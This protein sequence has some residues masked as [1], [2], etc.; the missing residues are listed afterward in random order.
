MS[1]PFIQFM[2]GP[3]VPEGYDRPGKW[4]NI[5]AWA[6]P[7][8]QEMFDR[9]TCVTYKKC[10]GKKYFIEVRNVSPARLACKCKK[11]QKAN[12]L[13][14][15]YLRK[16]LRKTFET[17]QR[18]EKFE[19]TELQ[20]NDAYKIFKRIQG[21]LFACADAGVLNEKEDA[22]VYIACNKP[23]GAGD[24]AF[25]MRAITGDPNLLIHAIV[26][27]GVETPQ[28]GNI[29]MAAAEHLHHQRYVEAQRKARK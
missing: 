13:A 26:T 8:R 16:E 12:E 19:D 2:F 17:N 1:Q 3:Q 11:C 23:Q 27:S 14:K 15:E 28:F 9:E 29:I 24:Y 4:F 7:A 6:L 25:S 20:D 18:L 21:E 5:I 22:V 10:L